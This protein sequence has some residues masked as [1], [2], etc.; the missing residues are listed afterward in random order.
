MELLMERG[1]EGMCMCLHVF[2]THTVCKYQFLSSV[3]LLEILL[4]CSQVAKHT[5]TCMCYLF[6]SL[7]YVVVID[8][9]EC[10]EADVSQCESIS[11]S[12]MINEKHHSLRMNFCK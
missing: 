5:F 8:Y 7:L 10:Q 1:K 12:S 3:C 11:G 6:S 9:T 4:A 2:G